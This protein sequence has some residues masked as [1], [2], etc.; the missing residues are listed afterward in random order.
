MNQDDFDKFHADNPEVWSLF[1]ELVF[2][3]INAGHQRG[4]VEMI[5]N[6]MRWNHEIE[7]TD[8][9]YKI[10]NNHKPYYARLFIEKCKSNDD[11]KYL[12]LV[13]YFATRSSKADEKYYGEIAKSTD[14]VYGDYHDR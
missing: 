9:F 5:F 6:I 14:K 11:P 8:P 10:N 1:V 2:K 3:H 12:K 13:D 7:T 4:S